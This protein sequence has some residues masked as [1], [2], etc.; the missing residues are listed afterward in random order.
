MPKMK[1][2]SMSRKPFWYQHLPLPEG[3]YPIVRP[4][5]SIIW[6]VVATIHSEELVVSS[7]FVYCG[8]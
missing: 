8:P 6:L 5:A 1:L 2:V 4:V 7:S 3:L